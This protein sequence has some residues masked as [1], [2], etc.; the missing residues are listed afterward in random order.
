M[1]IAA[2]SILC[3]RRFFH[4]L[5]AKCLSGSQRK[6]RPHVAQHPHILATK[7]PKPRVGQPGAKSNSEGA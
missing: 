3:Q 6:N 2:C 1:P 7:Q 4:L 5:P